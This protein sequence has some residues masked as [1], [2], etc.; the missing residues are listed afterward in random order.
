MASTF[1]PNAAQ[2]AWAPKQM[3]SSGM[4]ASSAV[5]SQACSSAIHGSESLTELS[6]PSTST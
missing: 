1:P 2:M 6:A 4:P 5:R 3:P